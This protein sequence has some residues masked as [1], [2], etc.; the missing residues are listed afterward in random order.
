[1][2]GG[3]QF[4]L[5]HGREQIQRLAS[6]FYADGPND[7][8]PSE[9]QRGRTE[10]ICH[11]ARSPPLTDRL[12]NLFEEPEDRRRGRRGRVGLLVYELGPGEAV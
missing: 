1:M 10:P 11:G 7:V 6:L 5:G 9:Q 8:A 3:G 12:L 2:Y 4:E